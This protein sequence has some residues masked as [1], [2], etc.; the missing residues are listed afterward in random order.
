[1]HTENMENILD[2]F[3]YH[4]KKLLINAQNLAFAKKH[5]FI[6]TD[7]ILISLILSK[8]SLGS[9]IL[10]K[11][12]IDTSFLAQSETPDQPMPTTINSE[13]LPQP[14]EETQKI[15][16]KAVVTSYKYHHKYIGTEHLLWGIIESD[17]KDIA[18]IFEKARLN[19]QI[20]RQHLN[21]ILKSTSKF[22]DLTVQE[23][24]KDLDHIMHDSVPE[25][26]TTN[27]FTMNLTTKEIQKKIYPV[28][29]RKK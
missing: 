18:K 28:I 7:D 10:I 22:S 17:S 3:T 12:K 23:E 1:M 27:N 6:E 13:K 4:F 16:E 11:Q 24:I 20:L 9:D 26:N 14:S 21:L 2:K 25:A 29:G 8:G 15:I 19:V 5:E